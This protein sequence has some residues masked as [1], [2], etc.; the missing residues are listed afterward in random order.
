MERFEN[1]HGNIWYIFDRKLTARLEEDYLY[2]QDVKENFRENKIDPD[3]P[4]RTG[5][6]MY[7]PLLPAAVVRRYALW[8]A[9]PLSITLKGAEVGYSIA[10]SGYAAADMGPGRRRLREVACTFRF[11][12]QALSIELD[13][14]FCATDPESLNYGLQGADK[15]EWFKRVQIAI[16]VVDVP[17]VLNMDEKSRRLFARNCGTRAAVG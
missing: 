4:L 13:M 6:S 2:L 16:P 14:T 9:L 1:R 11:A 15:A 7:I 10:N 8:R 5:P 12:E 17:E 3:A